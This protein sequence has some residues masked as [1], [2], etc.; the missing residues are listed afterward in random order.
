[1]RAPQDDNFRRFFSCFSAFRR[2]IEPMAPDVWMPAYETET[3]SDQVE[4]A[5]L[6]ME[7]AEQAQTVGTFRSNFRRMIDTALKNDS[8]DQAAASDRLKAVEIATEG[9][10]DIK[11]D[12]TEQ[13]VLGYNYIGAGRSGMRLSRETFANIET[14][15]EQDDIEQVV[16]HE[17]AH[18]QQVAL[19]GELVID[20]EAIDH[21][22]LYEGHAEIHG[23]EAVG[24]SK[25]QHREGQPDKLYREGQDIAVDIVRKV[26]RTA[27]ERALTKDGDLSKLQH[28][29]DQAIAA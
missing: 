14:A 8:L 3:G 13:G 2:I 11:L 16:A 29:Y 17:A 28:E 23:N 15:D 4:L 21:T 20:G 9:N 1:M 26:G 12:T 25:D 22:T 24:M 10:E 27:L 7:A 5:R 19:K 6:Q 18:G